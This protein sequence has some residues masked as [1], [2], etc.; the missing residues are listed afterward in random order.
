MGMW[1]LSPE[2]LYKW[3]K[4]C[5]IIKLPLGKYEEDQWEFR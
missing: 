3:G 4:S 5:I 1:K 2:Y